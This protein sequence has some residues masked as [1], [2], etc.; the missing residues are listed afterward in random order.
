MRSYLGVG[1]WLARRSA[2]PMVAGAL[3]FLAALLPVLGFVTFDF[4]WYSTVADHYLYVPM[5]GVALMAAWAGARWSGWPMR[6]GAAAVLGL[7]GVVSFLQTQYWADTRTLCLHQIAVNPSSDSGEDTLALVELEHGNNAQ[8][9]QLARR[10]MQVQPDD[11]WGCVYEGTALWRMDR[12]PEAAQAFRKALEV[13]HTNE[14]AL[15]GRA[16]V[17][18]GLGEFKQAELLQREVVKREPDSA[19]AHFKLGWLLARE[20]KLSE[21]IAQLQITIQLDPSRVDAHDLLADTLADAGQP[22]AALAEYNAA[23][24]LDPRDESALH[25]RSRLLGTARK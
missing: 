1:L 6:I 21:A 16:G 13:D 14:P 23:L 5:F 3:L 9:L 15:E 11:V 18:A 4:Q 10:A 20:Q 25:G 2:R 7:L 12:L 22:S 8:A 19:D 17:L 24:R